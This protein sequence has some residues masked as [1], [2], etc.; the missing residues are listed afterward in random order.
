MTGPSLFKTVRNSEVWFHCLGGKACNDIYKPVVLRVATVT[1][2][3]AD[4]ITGD[5]NDNYY[6]YGGD[7]DY[8]CG[9]NDGN[10]DDDVPLKAKAYKMLCHCRNLFY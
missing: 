9:D 10:D 7:S 2:T 3:S 8:S 6:S 4:I 1:A 5:N